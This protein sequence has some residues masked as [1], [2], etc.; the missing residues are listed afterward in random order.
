VFAGL[1]GSL[2][3]SASAPGA[4]NNEE[5]SGENDEEGETLT[6]PLPVFLGGARLGVS[7]SL[8]GAP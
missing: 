7:V 3:W 8:D 2:I 6:A 1:G 5:Q 4:T